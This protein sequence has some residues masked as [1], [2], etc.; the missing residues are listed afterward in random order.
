MSAVYV[1]S[2][3]HIGHT[4]ISQKFRSQFPSDDVHDRYILEQA[5]H[6]LTKRDVLYVIGDAFWTTSAL[7]KVAAAKIPCPMYLVRGNHDTLPTT[8]YLQV[9]KEVYGAFK[10][11]QYWMTHIPI[12]PQELYRGM[13]IHGH[14]HRG[15]PYETENDTRYFNAILEFNN[16]TPINVQRVGEIIQQRYKEKS[17]AREPRTVQQ[18]QV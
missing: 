12:H 13:N 15:G 6:T 1:T 18:H 2:D 10:Y 16:Y 17:C 5:K 7:E 14:C 4:G 3:W 8:D 11:K 9:F